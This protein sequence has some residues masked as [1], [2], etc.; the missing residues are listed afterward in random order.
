MKKWKSFVSALLAGIMILSAAS[1]IFAAPAFTDVSDHWAWTRGYIPY[2]VE[3]NVLNGYKLSNGTSVFKPEDKVTRAEFIKMLDETFGLVDTAEVSYSDVKSTDWHYPYFAKAIAQGYILNYGNYATPDGKLTREEAITLLVRYL[4]LTEAEKSPAS[5]FADYNSITSYYRDPVMAAAKAGLVDGYK[6]N[7]KTYFKPMNTL[8]RAEALTILYRAAGAIYNTSVSTKDS[9]AA[10]TNAVITRGGVVLSDLTLK[11]RV[12]VSEGVSGYS[13]TL[14]NTTVTDTMYVRGQSN[15]IINGKSVKNLIVD[16][17]ASDILITLSGG[18][19]VENLTLNTTAK[20]AIS[21]GTKVNNLNVNAKNV[22]VTGSGKIGTLNVE[23]SGMVSSIMPDTYHIGDGLTASLDGSVYQGSSDALAAFVFL[24]F[25]TEEDSYTYLNISPAV[26]G[27]IYYYYTDDDAAPSA[28]E[29]DTMYLNANRKDSF[30][31]TANKIYCESTGFT[32]NVQNYDYLVIQL[33]TKEKNHTPIIIPNEVSSGTGFRVDPELTDDTTIT[34][35]PESSGTVYY[36]YS[37]NGDKVTTAQFLDGYKNTKAKDSMYVAGGSSSRINLDS[38]YLDNYPYVVIMLQKNNNAYYTPVVVAAGDNGFDEEPKVSTLGSVSFTTKIT[39]TLYYYYSANGKAPSTA[40]YNTEWRSD[41]NRGSLSVTKGVKKSI[42]YDESVLAKYPYIIFSI[43]DANGNYTKPFVL[44][45]ESTSGFTVDPYLTDNSKISYR[46]VVN[47]TLY[48]YLSKT[49]SAPSTVADFTRSYEACASAYRGSEKAYVSGLN[50]FTYPSQYAASYPYIVLRLRGTDGTD[51]MPVVLELKVSASTG[52]AEQ[53]TLSSTSDT[54]R[55]RTVESGT[56]EYYY[57]RRSTANVDYTQDF[58]YMYSHAPSGYRDTV[59]VGSA[60][61]SIDFS[62][63]DLTLYDGIV[64]R[65][66][67]D[68]GVA[69][70]PVYLKLERIQTDDGGVY[71]LEIVAV[72]SDTV[73]VFANFSGTLYYH[74]QNYK[75]VSESEFYR[76]AKQ[77]SVSRNDMAAIPVDEDYNYI[78]LKLAHY[79]FL[80]IDLSDTVSD[81]GSDGSGDG[82]TTASG[83]GFLSCSNGLDTEGKTYITFIPQV[84]G[85][86]YISYSVGDSRIEIPVEAG[87]SYTHT[88]KYNIDE[89]LDLLGGSYNIQLVSGSTAYEKVVFN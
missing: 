42:Q 19:T 50:S 29:F 64:M 30:S 89:M 59:S 44:H 72:T 78:V 28:L 31:V 84:S 22:T 32:H 70:T 23:A 75:T 69:H 77:R 52:F 20:V 15:I 26:N 85:T 66:V 73:R 27:Q 65:F 82:G 10:D 41:Y 47:G 60:A 5:T 51:Y 3:K 43:K 24:P 36:Y 40:N 79:D 38:R 45:I 1:G 62:A 34:F 33:A 9:G 17:D 83:S 81:G 12:I 7:G 86:V 54:I 18:A 53:P 49:S 37:A 13:V 35:T 68:K 61:N 71:G 6:E 58:D 8:T 55:F 25:L 76:D 16:S 2:L 14:D 46:P 87:Q 88:F 4:D 57:A 39:G 21:N 80:V 63:I 67:N 48:W 11:G 74:F 56:V